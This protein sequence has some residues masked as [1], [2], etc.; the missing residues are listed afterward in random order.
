MIE[1]EQS[2][3]RGTDQIDSGDT[4][5]PDSN[6]KPN[7]RIF[8]RSP[9][10]TCSL[11]V[12]VAIVAV[13]VAGAAGCGGNGQNHQ[14]YVSDDSGSDVDT[15]GCSDDMDCDASMYCSPAVLK[16]VSD[17]CVPKVRYCE[18][19]TVVECLP[20]G[21]GWLD[22]FTCESSGYFESVCLELSED[23]AACTC[24]DDWDCPSFAF[25]EAGVCLGTG[26]KP[27][28]SLP[29]KP[30]KD[31]LPSI[32]IQWGGKVW[33][34]DNA[35]G[36]PFPS[37]SQAVMS[38]LVVNLN[39]D[40]EDGEINERDFPEIVFATFCGFGLL[41]DPLAQMSAS[42]GV[43]RAIHGGGKHKGEDYF[44][45]CGN[46]VWHEGDPVGI[47]YSCG[48]A[49]LN[50]IASLA[51][52]DLDGDGIPE[53]VAVLEGIN[54]GLGVYSNTGDIIY[55]SPRLNMGYRTPGITLANLD[56]EGFVEII[57]GRHVY[58]LEHDGEGKLRIRDSFEGD[59]AHGTQSGSGPVSCV[60]DLTGD[61]R[62]EIVAATTV[63]DLPRPP[64][65]VEKRAECGGSYENKE[66]TAF[67]EGKLLVLWD[68]QTI[69]PGIV[70]EGFCA[71][72]D[73]LGADQGASPGPGNPLDGV[74]EVVTISD[75]HLQIFNGQNGKLRRNIE[76]D[77]ADKGGAP[78]VDDFDGDGFPEIGSA[79]QTTYL[80]MDLQEP[81]QD[82]P[83]WNIPFRDGVT[84]LQGNPPRSGS[85]LHNGWARRTRDGSSKV[86]GSSVFDFNGDGAAEVVYNDE[87]YFRIYDGANGQV[88][89]KEGSPSPTMIE[90]PVIAD[91][92]NDGNA[93]IV[94]GTS[95]VIDSCDLLNFYNNGLEVWGDA[96]D[97]W[98][99]A[100]RIWNQHSYHVTNVLESGGLPL[101]EPESWK[102]HGDRSYNSYRSNPHSQGVAPDLTITGLQISSPDTPCGELSNILSITARLENKGDLR[103]GPGVE[104]SF[105]GK[106]KEP[107][108]E[109]ALKADAG[110]T[111][112]RSVIFASLEPGDSI[113]LTAL[114]DAVKTG[115][116]SVP[117]FVRAVVDEDGRESECNELNNEIEI[118]VD[119]G[120]RRP[121]LTVSIGDVD[122]DR[123]PFLTVETTVVNVGSAPAKDVLVRYY[124][125]DPSQGG[126][127]IHQK[128]I[129]GPL[130]AGGG[131]QRIVETM[132]RSFEGKE[133]R[134]WAV[135]DPLD[136]IEECADGNNIAAAGQRS[137]CPGKVF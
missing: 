114:Y 36:S 116:G 126:T 40:N 11:S 29:P 22:L 102:P 49:D 73:V 118:A 28:C 110:G 13:S 137:G 66:H 120:N 67:C 12:F 70:R 61:S 90:Y 74:A 7:A 33:W 109:E 91:V 111:P 34:K 82:C 21:S 124:A 96:A 8:D 6:G 101:C 46:K 35:E 44:A 55:K 32:E 98:V 81:T 119:P 93:E 5:K 86:T 85:C 113:L 18:G 71:V 47:N 97:S 117:S 54:S 48:G 38:P 131:F 26:I 123:C 69:S 45:V 17:K 100:R 42:D 92:D 95:N 39:D 121:D 80:V 133:I 52:G 56:N 89:F 10:R 129:P 51:A 14:G 72:A 87:C 9:K 19:D 94:F 59:L 41:Q 84:G 57:V 103:I 37:S 130:G 25:C 76:I 75:G 79:F 77:S 2:Q 125:G 62:K 20:N 127:T 108:L 88:L 68:G 107:A 135:V 128:L 50:P 106:W 60:A 24:E 65:G 112:L 78:N 122:T 104:V 27:G 43:L 31:V 99:S 83:Q 15:D 1:R 115:P 132:P 63:Y 3:T 53:I 30:F 58:T 64:P 4:T 134:I 105:Y 16:C 136:T 23:F